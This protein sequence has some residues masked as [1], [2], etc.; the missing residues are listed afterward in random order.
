MPDGVWSD[1]VNIVHVLLQKTAYVLKDLCFPPQQ[2]V[3]E[4]T[5]LLTPSLPDISALLH[6]TLYHAIEGKCQHTVRNYI[7]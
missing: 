5:D 7:F 2:E 6:S 1:I 3:Y 4:S